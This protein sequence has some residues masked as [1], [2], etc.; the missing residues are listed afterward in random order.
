MQSSQRRPIPKRA[1]AEQLPTHR[2][3]H[4]S[5][6]HPEDEPYLTDQRKRYP[7]NPLDLADDLDYPEE[8]TR[9]PTSAVRYVDTRGN[10]VIERGNK[11]F[12]I[13]DEPLPK[14]RRRLHWSAIFGIGMIVMVI[15]FISWVLLT[16][17][18][19]QHQLDT[20]YEFPRVSQADAVV[21][22]GDTA[23]HPSHYLFLNLN[24]T[25]LIVELP[26]GDS[27]KSR[28]YKGPTIFSDNAAQAPITGEFRVM[29]GKVEMLVH[30]QDRIILYINNG[31]QFIPQ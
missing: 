3:G 24:G 19:T 8:K 1:T 9:M 11:R 21:Y 12:V 13:H 27:A 5:G 7:N 29:N 30:I 10:Q 28:I 17:W 15:L 2:A 6:L 22:P 18:W 26:H 20:T 31:T 14:Q 4:Y 23:D 25:V 16:N